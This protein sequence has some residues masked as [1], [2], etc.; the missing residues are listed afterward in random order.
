VIARR[1]VAAGIALV[2]ACAPGDDGPVGDS[3]RDALT[4]S[5]SS[6]GDTTGTWVPAPVGAATFVVNHATRGMAARVR[7]AFAPDG[8]SL[9]VVEDPAGVEN[10]AVP[11][12]VLFATEHTGRTWRMDSVWSVAPSPDWMHVAVGRA[13]VLGGGERQVVAPSR[14]EDAARSLAAIA[15]PN[16]SIK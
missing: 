16:E 11:D 5:S 15:G 13:V 2:C 4:Q 9:L 6:R 1:A 3:A 7:W 8:G 10:E 12:G 14:W